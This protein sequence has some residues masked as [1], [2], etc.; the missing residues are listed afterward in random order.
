MRIKYVYVIL[1]RRL[2]C[3]NACVPSKVSSF[4]TQA[5]NAIEL[6]D[7]DEDDDEV[8]IVQPKQ[9][10]AAA[11]PT[12]VAASTT[13]TAAPNPTPTIRGERIKL[14]VRS[15]GAAIDEVAIHKVHSLTMRVILLDAD[16]LFT[17]L[18]RA[19]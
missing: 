9:Q 19:E 3:N 2:D 13:P 15:N 6:L 12:S 1:W 16:G 18:W 5:A 14:Q 8:E 7:S 11:I 10:S 17:L 4:Q